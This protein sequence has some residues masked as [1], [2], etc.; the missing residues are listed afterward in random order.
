M[1]YVIL[2]TNFL[3]I[4]KQFNVD[5]FDEIDRLLISYKLFVFDK[6]LD[7]IDDRTTMALVKH[8]IENNSLNIIR[9]ST[10][11]ID[12]AIVD[13]VKLH[14]NEYDIVIATQDQELK[15]RLKDYRVSFIVLRGKNHLELIE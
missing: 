2:D 13:F 8:K 4:P 1:K 6:T 15:R 7:E 5:I 9:T 10:S 11:Y 14:D 12:D 3:Y